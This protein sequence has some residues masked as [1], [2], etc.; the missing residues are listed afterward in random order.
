[1]NYLDRYFQYFQKYGD[2]RGKPI[3]AERI[4]QSHLRFFTS[5]WTNITTKNYER[6]FASSPVNIKKYN[7][8]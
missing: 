1:L 5:H 3:G 4:G 6:W 2:V 8:K 7:F